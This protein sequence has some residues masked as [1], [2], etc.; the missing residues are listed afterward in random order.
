MIGSGINTNSGKSTLD[1]ESILVQELSP[2]LR[3]EIHV[4]FPSIECDY[5]KSVV[6][7]QALWIQ[8]SVLARKMVPNRVRTPEST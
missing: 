2:N 4:L 5:Q 8:E 7:F 1:S 3:I 6:Q